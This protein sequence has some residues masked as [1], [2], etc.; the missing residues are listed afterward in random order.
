MVTM[1]TK[2]TKGDICIFGKEIETINYLEHVNITA[3]Q[4]L[5]WPYVSIK[6]HIK[7]ASLIQGNS[8]YKQRY[9]MIS[10]LLELDK[11]EK[12]PNILSGGNKR[13]LCT[14]LTL[15]SVPKLAYFDEPTVGLDPVARR[16]LLDLIKNS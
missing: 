5:L 10:N 6:E 11:P 4:D 1:Q 9:A 16:N 14:A 8:N 13:K 2:R 3:Q 7:I 12:Y 15:F